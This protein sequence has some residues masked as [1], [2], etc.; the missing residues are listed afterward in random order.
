MDI[1]KI[2]PNFRKVPRLFAGVTIL[3][4]SLVIFLG[5]LNCQNPIMQSEMGMSG[6]GAQHHSMADCIPGQDCGMDINEHLSIWQSMFLTNLNTNFL[7]LLAGLIVVGLGLAIFK[8]PLTA[9]ITS[10]TSR[11]LYYERDHQDSKLYNYFIQIFSSG[12]V[13]PKLYA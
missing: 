8:T 2:T 9:Q 4:F 10:L 1:S 7:I 6:G 13:A 12:I 3:G 11:Y 5:V